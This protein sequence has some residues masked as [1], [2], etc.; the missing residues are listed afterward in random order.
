MVIFPILVH[1]MCV[2]DSKK[3]VVTYSFSC[4]ET[5]CERSKNVPK[6]HLLQ[7]VLGTSSGHQLKHFPCNRF[8]GKFFYIPNT[9]CIPDIA[10]PNV[11]FYY[12]P[13]RLDQITTIRGRPRDVLCRL[14]SIFKFEEDLTFF[15]GFI[16][17]L[18]FKCSKFLIVL[19]TLMDPK[20]QAD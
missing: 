10:E 5:S 17:L 3:L 19:T 14:G 4:G 15:D 13:G 11:W 20:T 9:K 16:A 6:W 8:L 1:Q 12:G 18:R 7:D 2:L